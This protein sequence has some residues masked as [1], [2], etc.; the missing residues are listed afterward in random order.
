MELVA[1][2]A[3]GQDRRAAPAGVARRDQEQSITPS[4]VAEP[5]GAAA[6]TKM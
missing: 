4:L 1:G 5:I 3:A 2:R 6:P